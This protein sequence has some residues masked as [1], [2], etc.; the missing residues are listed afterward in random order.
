MKLGWANMQC[1]ASYTGITWTLH[2]RLTRNRFTAML[3]SNTTL[4]NRCTA[5]SSVVP[6]KA[7][8]SKPIFTPLHSTDDQ[9]FHKIIACNG[10]LDSTKSGSPNRFLAPILWNQDEVKIPRDECDY[11]MCYTYLWDC[12]PCVLGT[13]SCTTEGIYIHDKLQSWFHSFRIET[14]RRNTMRNIMGT[15]PSEQR[16]QAYALSR[17]VLTDKNGM[18]RQNAPTVMGNSL[19]VNACFWEQMLTTVTSLFFSLWL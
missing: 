12:L 6:K 9:S 19:V 14:W 11:A 13:Y 18:H 2:V 8:M 3:C 17:H 16:G 15:A 7:S 10:L 1:L 5:H 4:Q